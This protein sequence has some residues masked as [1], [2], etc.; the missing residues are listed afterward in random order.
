M[1]IWLKQ[2]I[3]ENMNQGVIIVLKGF[4]LESYVTRNISLA[5]LNENKLN[6]FL[7]ISMLEEKV[8]SYD[9]YIALYDFVLAQYEKVVILENNLYYN[10]YPLNLSLGIEVEFGLINHFDVEIN[11]NVEYDDLIKPYLDIYSNVIKVNDKVY[12]TYNQILKDEKETF[13]DV[14]KNECDGF[15]IENYNTG[16]K[17]FDI[18]EEI[19]YLFAIQD[20][21]SG[22][23]SSVQIVKSNL[24][25]D[26]Q[27]LMKKMS[28]VKTFM[29]DIDI[30]FVKKEKSKLGGHVDPELKVILKKYWKAEK[31]REIQ[32]YDIDAVDNGNREI[33]IISQGDVITQLVEQ[34]EKCKN[35]ETFRDIFVTASTGAGKSAMFQIPAIH[36]ADKYQL[37]TIVIS[38]LIG[39]MQD[40]VAGLDIRGYGYSRTMNSDISPIK[41]QEII[42]EIANGECHI[43]YI[44]PESLLGK[45]DLIQIIGPRKLGMLIIDEAHIVTTWGKQFRPDYWYLGDHIMKLRKSQ[46]KR[47]GMQFVIATFTA[48]AIYGGLE[49]MYQETIQSLHMIDP[50]TYLGYVRRSDIDIKVDKV[51]LV[52]NKSEYELDK[53]EQLLDQVKRC[54]IQNKKMLI[55]FPTVA[56]IERFFDFCKY[57]GYE[58]YVA[59]YHG[60]L[61]GFAKE[62]NYLQFKNKE[63]HVMIATKAFGMGID[64]DD[65][66]IV[67][68]F[69][70]T[71][72]V[73]DYLQEIGRAARRP[74]LDG[75]AQ[76][77]YM[78]NDFKHINRLHGLSTI[79]E[80]QLVE[81]IKKIYQLHNDNIQKKS[82]KRLTKKRN[83]MLVDAESFAHIFEN[84]FFNEEDG[85]NKVKT[86]M[87]LIQKDF[88]RTMSYSPFYVRPIPLF[89]IGFFKINQLY[90]N[91]LNKKY[92]NA[93]SLINEEKGVYNVNLKKIWEKS[94][95]SKYSFP[96]FKYMLYSK[97]KELNFEYL[98]GFDPALKVDVKLT[99]D[100]RTEFGR[101]NEVLRQIITENMRLGTFLEF[102]EMVSILSKRLNIS[103]YKAKNI[104]DV[105]LAAMRLYSKEFSKLLHSNPFK[106]KVLKTGAIKYNFSNVSVTYFKW[107]EQG[108]NFIE[109]NLSDGELYLCQNGNSSLFKEYLLILGVLESYETLSFK[110]LGGRNSQLYIYVNQTKTMKEIIAKPKFYKNRL[111]ELVAHRHELSVLMLTYL[112][113]ND[114]TSEETWDLLEDYFIGRIPEPVLHKFEEK[115]GG[116]KISEIN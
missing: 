75:E 70:P 62:E 92:N 20:L 66:E 71:G 40:Q 109:E 21:F 23:H 59:K 64:I 31:F 89:E 7:S 11:E 101:M 108:M 4:H 43:L 100:H 39:L 51:K 83:E 26:S 98:D 50:I 107:L 53:F 110:A 17:T 74:T 30:K 95:G 84:P 61:D 72:N 76:Y 52:T 85:I 44:S 113:E 82:E 57:Q 48:T 45:S 22:N 55:Y 19:D 18:I 111:L 42:D 80:Y 3:N 77:K 47:E 54:L 102:D 41:K 105:T 68:H 8:I 10:F 90:I 12:V 96:K 78:S 34:V 103:I 114:F 29:P 36:F 25:L 33:N 91:K 81:V 1:D 27:E 56:L 5:T 97:D 63:K 94:F 46:F 2:L 69:A 65:I 49:N 58:K 88:E 60:K 35:G 37:F 28:I 32:I 115:I 14:F 79:K 99:K 13:V 15:Q 73:C 87:L 106:T 9:E 24:G 86:A 38:P 104:V 116:K 112:F 67:M 93:F 6:Y 16:L